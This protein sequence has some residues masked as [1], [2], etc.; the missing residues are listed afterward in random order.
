MAESTILPSASRDRLYQ[1]SRRHPRTYPHILFSKNNFSKKFLGPFRGPPGLKTPPSN[2]P[3]RA[4]Y[5]RIFPHLYTQLSLR[6]SS[7]YLPPTSPLHHN[8]PRHICVIVRIPQSL[9][10]SPSTHF[11]KK[12]I[13]KILWA[14]SRGPRG[15]RPH[16]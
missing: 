1:T 7:G 15:S 10:P 6:G 12:Q 14:L 11:I 4:T 13:F 5:P 2:S 9:R 16:F 8:V 3:S